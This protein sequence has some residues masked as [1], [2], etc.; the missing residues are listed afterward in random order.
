MASWLDVAATFQNTLTEVD[1][2]IALH[3]EDIQ[4]ALQSLN[5]AALAFNSFINHANETEIVDYVKE[6]CM[7]MQ[8][9]AQGLSRGEGTLSQLMNNQNLYVQLQ[10]VLR[11]LETVLHDISSYGIFYQFSSK[12]S[13]LNEQ[14]K[15]YAE[16]TQG[17]YSNK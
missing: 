5:A 10:S 15:N 4:Q 8:D 7:A 16:M 17:P 13:R 3:K 12:W 11:H 2:F 9:A 6:S 1:Q 14:R